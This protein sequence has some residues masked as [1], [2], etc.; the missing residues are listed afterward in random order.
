MAS[1]QPQP[2]A[3][4]TPVAAHFRDAI[5]NA[6]A[7]GVA[8]ENMTLRLTLA[9]ESRL[10]RDRSVALDDIHFAHGVM[11]YLEVKVVSGGVEVSA[12]DTA[13]AN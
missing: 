11:R 4:R 1:K 12:L 8:R 3:P 10:R 9:D 7:A 2:T 13:S 6:E 5:A